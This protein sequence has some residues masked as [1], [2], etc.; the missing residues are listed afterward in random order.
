[1]F[2]HFRFC[3]WF[4]KFYN[5]TLNGSGEKVQPSTSKSSASLQILESM[6][7][8]NEDQEEDSSTA[9]DGDNLL[10]K[11]QS[12]LREY[13]KEKRLPLHEDP[14]MWWNG[15]AHKYNNILPIVRQYLSAPPSSVAS[16]QLFSGAGLIYEEHRNRLKGEKAAK[17][18][19]IK[20]NLPL[21]NFDY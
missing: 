10:L 2:F 9:D 6:L 12:H 8:V 11:I 1:M 15:N 7:S 14:L 16:E 3:F 5:R 21:F 20:Y 4:R 13:K 19:F 17:L 18:L